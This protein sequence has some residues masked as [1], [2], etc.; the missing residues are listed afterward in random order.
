MLLLFTNG[1]L[2]EEPPSL[3]WFILFNYMRYWH[4]TPQVGC[5]AISDGWGG[6]LTLAR[7]S[8]KFPTADLSLLSVGR[9]WRWV[10]PDP[11]HQCPQKQAKELDFISQ[12]ARGDHVIDQVLGDSVFE[13]SNP[14]D[15]QTDHVVSPCTYQRSQSPDY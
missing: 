14:Q 3:R 7:S 5:H 4:G 9:C 12:S 10:E 2:H 8:P 15:S 11:L 6:Y 1:Y 13:N